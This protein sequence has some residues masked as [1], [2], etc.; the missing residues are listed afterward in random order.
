VLTCQWNVRQPFSAGS[1]STSR[2][3]LAQTSGSGT[4]MRKSIESGS[5]PGWSLQ[6]H[7]KSAPSPWQVVAIQCAPDLVFFQV[8]PPSQGGI[9]ASRGVPE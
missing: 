6:G 8:N 2:P 9:G 4:R 3:L 5:S 1:T 7:H